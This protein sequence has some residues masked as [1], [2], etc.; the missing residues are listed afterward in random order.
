MQNIVNLRC[1]GGHC[2]YKRWY[3]FS[4]EAECNYQPIYQLEKAK[5]V[6]GAKNITFF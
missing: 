5:T 4:I 1:V 3:K 6:L 2:L